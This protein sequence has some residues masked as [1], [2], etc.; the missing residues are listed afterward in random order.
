MTKVSLENAPNTI[1]FEMDGKTVYIVGTAHIS[2]DS[3]Q[4][5]QTVI[6]QVQ[7]DTVCIELC[8]SRYQSIRDKDRWKK[9]NIIEVLKKKQGFLLFSN[10][11]L[12]SF[13][14]RA[15]LDLESAPGE[16]MIKAADLAEEAGIPI[17]LADR[18]VNVTLRRAW[19]KSGFFAK[20]RILSMLFDTVLGS[21]DEITEDD[22]DELLEGSSLFNDSIELFSKKLPKVK[23]VLI[24]E[25]DRFLSEKIKNASGSA[26][27]AVVGK[28]HQQGILKTLESNPDYNPEIETL[29]PK[30]LFGKIVPWLISGGILALFV[31]GFFMKGKETALNMALAWIIAN[32]IFTSLGALLSLAHPLTILAAWVVSP[33]TS[34][35]P[36]IGAGLVLGVIEASLRKPRV[37]DFEELPQDIMSFKGFFKNRITRTLLVFVLTSVGS[38]IGTFWGISWISTLLG[39]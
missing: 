7:P 14:K 10:M 5:V 39:K 23:E 19:S 8:D 33:I 15:G 28:G 26:V 27:V 22:I 18:D 24:D 35:N 11:I 29:P 25:R 38:L 34:L 12:S 30:N 36:T 13:Q 32:G 9:L 3:V 1:V 31:A 17:V 20:L 4:E 21:S 6:E 37:R 16:E 2:Q